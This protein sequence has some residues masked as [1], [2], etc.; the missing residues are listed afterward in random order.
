MRRG[1]L[2]DI[3]ELRALKGR[4]S[5]KPFD[6]IYHALRTRCSLILQSAPL[7]EAQWRNLWL[8]GRWCAALEAAKTTQGRIID[9]LVAHH[10]DANGAYRDRAIEELDNLVSWS[11]WVDPSIKGVAADL[12]TAESAVTATVA[13]DWLWDD[14]DEAHRSDV[15]GAIRTKVVEAYRT[16]VTGQAWW[17]GCY[18]SWNAVVNSGCGLAALALGDEDE[19]ADEACQW[20]LD[21]LGRFFDALGDEGGWDEGTGY[22]GYAM[23]YLLLFARA[24]SRLKDDQSIFHR[25]GMDAT[26]QFP[27]YF[28]PNGRP[29]SF[30]DAPLVPLY[31]A[32]Y[33]LTGQ[34]NCRQL[35]WWLDTY[36]F[37]HDVITSGWA[38][39]GLALLFRPEDAPPAPEVKLEPVKVFTQI[40]WAALADHWPKP[41]FYVAAK[42]GDLSAN[43]SQRDMNSIQLQVDGEML[44]TDPGGAPSS[45]AYFSDARG[46]FYEVQA[47][48][49]NT[50]IVAERDHLIDAHGRIVDS[51]CGQRYRWV[52]CDA[53]TACGENVQFVRH[54]V[55]PA[56]P[57][58]QQGHTLIVLDELVNGVPETV[59]MFW[60]TQGEL[61]LDPEKSTG[62]IIG[63]RSALGFAFACTTRASMASREHRLDAR[64]RDRVIHITAGVIDSALFASVFSREPLDAPPQL[65]RV[66]GQVTVRCPTA[67]VRLKRKGRRLKLESV[68]A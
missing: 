49:H 2:A 34:T 39:A 27:I 61:R 42:T 60:H 57:H 8:N 13:L 28:T 36:A 5:K 59:E 63:R 47:R 12:C 24:L 26:G 62:A 29:A 37:Q 46:E 35:L 21:G 7:T 25:R 67:T 50:V 22:W 11:A 68:R 33:L 54:L 48:A 44:L 16:A 55:M 20:A 14:L 32:L 15:I 65:E 6:A 58:T 40:G 56:D 53:M 38:A 4:I 3:D 45:D 19:R 1:I 9:L 31:G 41:D 52:A 23:R 10:I 64:R 30:G 18:H 43:H 17:Y 51:G 66:D